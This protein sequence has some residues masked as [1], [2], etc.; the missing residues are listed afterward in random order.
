MAA[1]DAIALAALRYRF[2]N[3]GNAITSSCVR[4][5]WLP[6]NA[7]G[8]LSAE[9]GLHPLLPDDGFMRPFAEH[10]RSDHSKGTSRGK[11]GSN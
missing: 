8:G 9:S 2:A 6:P 5:E 3:K 10:V 1:T 4:D 11:S 7:P